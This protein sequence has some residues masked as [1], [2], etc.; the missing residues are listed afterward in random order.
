M[1]FDYKKPTVQMLG[2][3]QPVHSSHVALFERAHA[4]T[5]QV[6]IMIRDVE[7]VGDNPFDFDTVRYKFIEALEAKGYVHEKDFVIV[8]VP[9]IVNI[10][11][12]RDVGYKIEQEIFNDEVHA[13]SAT[14]I[15]EEMRQSGELVK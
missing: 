12:G 2:R 10:T 11:Y 9:N 5:G 3:F 4:K 7:G 8:L 13:V 14:K 1:K 6:C 15:R